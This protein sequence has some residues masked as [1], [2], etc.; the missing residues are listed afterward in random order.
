MAD[1]EQTFQDK[2]LEETKNINTDSNQ[3]YL[4]KERFEVHFNTP[5]P[6]YNCNGAIAYKVKDKINPNRDLFAMICDNETPPR[7]S[8]LPYLKSIDHPNIL[9]LVEY[10]VVSYLPKDSR[11]MA[12]IYQTPVG[13]KINADNLKELKLKDNSEKIKTILLSLLSAIETLKGHGI[14]HRSIRLDNLYFKD[15][16]YSEIIVGDC[17]ACF[18]AFYQNPVYETIES[19]IAQKEGRGDGNDRDDIYAIGAVILSLIAGRELLTDLTLP[20]IIRLKLKKGSYYVLS[21]EERI[22]KQYTNIIK[23][24]IDDN[25]ENRWSY[26]QAYNSL[27]GKPINFNNSSIVERPKKSLTI[28]GEKVYTTKE[29]AYSLLSSP[30]EAFDLI[31][32]GKVSDWIKNGLENEKIYEKIDKL[33]KQDIFLSQNIEI[34]VAKICILLAPSLPIK[35]G[36]LSL[37]PDGAPKAIFYTIKNKGSIQPYI[38]FFSSDLIKMWYLE[39]ENMRSPTNS[40]EFKIYINRKDIGYGI[41]RI[42]YD[43]DEDL[44]CISPLIGDEFVNSATRILK[45]LDNTYAKKKMQGIPYDKTIIAYLRCKMGKKIDGIII[46]LNSNK[47]EIQSSAILRLYTNMQNKYGPIQL[48]N[49]SRW[50]VSSSISIVKSYHNLK[51]QKFLEREVLKASKSGKLEDIC[52]I[53]ENSEAKQKDKS[54]FAK[55]LNDINYLTNEKNKI[56]IGGNKNDEEAFDLAI[57]FSSMLAVL[58]MIASFIFNLIYWIMK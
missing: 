40:G 44:P 39:Q 15:N 36:E 30:Q 21:N 13:E 18:P 20:E 4:I 48:S 42:M 27:E 45:A 35:I 50:L 38:E 25:L 37:F 14:S 24:L 12:L 49:L 23:G 32:S 11:N 9:K 5:L 31:K 8:I 1:E 55:A 43:F 28:N 34:F 57:K 19:L 17:A 41:D 51:Y 26:I 6:K 52:N 10:S 22:P 7:S 56:L 54:D 46:D 53:L 47:E 33:I 3:V 29:V 2:D 58:T 16:S